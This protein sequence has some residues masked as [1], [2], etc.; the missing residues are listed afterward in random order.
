M[1]TISERGRLR[2]CATWPSFVRV[3]HQ[4]LPLAPSAEGATARAARGEGAG[5]RTPRAERATTCRPSP[6]A[7]GTTELLVEIKVEQTASADDVLTELGKAFDGTLDGTKLFFPGK[8]GP[9]EMPAAFEQQEADKPLLP[10]VEEL[11]ARLPPVLRPAPVTCITQLSVEVPK[12]VQLAEGVE[13]AGAG[14]GATTSPRST[15]RLRHRQISASISSLFA[16]ASSLEA[17][18]SR[19]AMRSMRSMS[20]YSSLVC[21]FALLCCRLSTCN[22]LN[23]KKAVVQSAADT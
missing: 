6:F 4:C 9:R 13:G 2:L 14:A 20:K 10:R 21:L 3:G 18:S 16:F 12:E 17:A 23:G 1:S 15:F 7:V 22:I 19:L 8:A 5:T 11:L